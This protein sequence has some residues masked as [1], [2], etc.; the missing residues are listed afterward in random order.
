MPSNRA[1]RVGVP[2]AAECHCWRACHNYGQW[3]ILIGEALDALAFN[4][5]SARCL[6]IDRSN[7]VQVKLSARRAYQKFVAG[8]LTKAYKKVERT[9]RSAA[10]HMIGVGF[11]ICYGFDQHFKI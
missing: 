6:L 11:R 8:L 1:A 2:H 7:I 4:V 3:Y 5:Y 10:A 9:D